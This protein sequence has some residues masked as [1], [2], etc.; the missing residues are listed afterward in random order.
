[1]LIKTRLKK[2]LP[3]SIGKLVQGSRDV[4]RRASE[5]AASRVRV[6]RSR[7]FARHCTWRRQRVRVRPAAKRGP[8]AR[9]TR[10]GPP[11]GRRRPFSSTT[12]RTLTEGI[13][14][15]GL[16]GMSKGVS[17]NNERPDP[18][19]A[20]VHAAT[21]T[22]NE[23]Y[24]LCSISRI[25]FRHLQFT[26]MSLSANRFAILA[27]SSSSSSAKQRTRTSGKQ[28]SSLSF[29]G[30]SSDSSPP[31]PSAVHA[32]SAHSTATSIP[33]STA[34]TGNRAA[35]KS[36]PTPAAAHDGFAPTPECRICQ[37][38]PEEGRMISPCKCKGSMKFVHA[39]CLQKWR[40]L[41]SN[42]KSFFQCEQCLYKCVIFQLQYSSGLLLDR[43]IS[44]SSYL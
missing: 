24:T 43:G 44:H 23:C 19:L 22:E 11:W 1:M 21:D 7:D 10:C 29:A 20:K 34:P 12:K 8:M 25:I 32:T 13:R 4:A 16:E 42:R 41:S 17:L 27:A 30:A 6:E 14:L 9:G 3:L 36:A 38:G 35:L 26:A 5:T 18:S 37:C 31:A 39:E 28:A 33:S 15:P 40:E 2:S